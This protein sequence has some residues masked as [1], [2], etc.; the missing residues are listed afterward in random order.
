MQAIIYNYK[1][2]ISEV[3]P[4]ILVPAMNDILHLADYHVLNF[5]DHNFTPQ[6]HTSLWLLAESHL[7]IHT[8]P[9]EQKAY[10]ELSSCSEAKNK[11]FVAQLQEWIQQ[12][13]I[14]SSN[15][16]FQTVNP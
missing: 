2:W 15:E 10:I 1:V 8:F 7:A 14:I 13:S 5:M 6:G 11:V 16:T 3:E 4:E 9:E 12:N